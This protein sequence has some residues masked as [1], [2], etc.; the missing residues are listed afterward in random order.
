MV[1]RRPS[2]AAAGAAACAALAMWLSFGALSFVD[3]ENRAPYV[4]VMPPAGWLIVL[5]VVAGALVFA[6]R[7]SARAVSPLWLSTVV[8][9][10]WLP[11]PV[12]LSAF[13]W[14][15]NML[16]W[17]WAA[18]AIAVAAPAAARLV[19]SRRLLQLPPQRAAIAAGLIAAAAYGAAAWSTAP[20]HPNGDEPHYLIITQSLLLDGD[21][22]IEN[23]HKRADYASYLGR[24]LPSPH[25]M[26]RGKNGEIYS[27]HA[28]GLPAIVAPAF[29]LAGYRGVIVELVALAAAAAALAWLI[30]FRVTGDAAASWFGWA[31]VTMSVPFFFHATAIFPDGLGAMLVL[32]AL[33]PLVDPRAREPRWLAAV[34]AALAVLP[35]LHSR[36]AML[37]GAAGLVIAARI[38]TDT[39][40]VLGSGF[41]VQG[42]R[43]VL[44][45]GFSVRGSQNSVTS[46]GYRLLAFA[47]VPMVS[48][49]AWLLFFQ[50]IYGTPNPSV[51]NDLSNSMA[52]GNIVRSVPGLLADQQYG[53]IANAP[54]YL[55]AIA[56]IVVMLLRGPR[57]LAVELVAIAAPYVL[58][59]TVY[60]QWW[61]GTTPPARFLVPVTLMMT[62]PAAVWFAR[63]A[64]ISS[65]VAGIAALLVSLLMTATIAAVGR[66]GFVFN[67][68]DGFS[69]VAMWLSPVVDLPRALPS[70]FQSP[71][72]TMVMQAAVWLVAVG[73]AVAAGALCRRRG[74]EAIVLAFGLTLEI[75]AMAAI[76]IVWRTNNAAAPTPSASG[77]A[78]LR[79]WSAGGGRI[80]LGY[81]PFH[82][83]DST[84][85]PGDI[86]LARTLSSGGQAQQPPLAHLPAGVYELRGRSAGAEAGRLRVKTDR[87]SGPIAEWDAASLESTWMRQVSIPLAVSGLQI[88]LDPAARKAIRDVSIRAVSLQ[89]RKDTPEQR[90][91][92]R[93][94][95]SGPATIFFMAGDAWVEPGGTWIAGRSDAEFAIATEPQ[96]PLQVLVRNGPVENSVR[97]SSAAWH[98]TLQLNAGEERLVKVPSDEHGRTTPLKVEAANGFRPAEVDPGSED[99]RL[100]GVWIETR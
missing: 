67:D 77:P 92:R 4:G 28:P 69:R 54:V 8:L 46:R 34:G 56:G 51:T 93:A 41:W 86:V 12:P 18:I 39:E 22:K 99:R 7:P 6:L 66:G 83:L 59:L 40:R 95:R 10:P 63:A 23:N 58:L 72:G 26:T 79:K 85:L 61:G 57:R 65:R 1:A 76:G 35:W 88:E 78:V 84:A 36:F 74:R 68:R 70:L 50:V 21:L 13:I 80:A 62:V 55:C 90:E 75:A 97:L 45:S 89:T 82:R 17:L 73:A 81:R 43:A 71:P 48:A 52:A 96:A 5:L 20:A 31:A 30:A 38:V 32:P 87:V 100:L 47:A 33:L 44:G 60:Y 14:T 3:A 42:S 49:A 27:L 29:A 9:L 11:L 24:S 16:L 15:G 53:L 37:A 91:A 2:S 98:E 19:R 25:F 64:S 94:A